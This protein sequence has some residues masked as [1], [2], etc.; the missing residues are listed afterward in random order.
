MLDSNMK[1]NIAEQAV[2]LAAARLGVPVLRP[3]GESTRRC[4]LALEIG[5]RL[6]RVQCKWARLSPAGDTV[7]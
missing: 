3:M 7:I 2:V 6:W 1:G 4:D 5:G